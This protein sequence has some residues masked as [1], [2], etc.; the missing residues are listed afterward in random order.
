MAPEL[1]YDLLTWDMPEIN[2]VLDEVVLL[3]LNEDSEFAIDA[4]KMPIINTV[5]ALK[6]NDFNCLRSLLKVEIVDHNPL[7]YEVGEC[8]I[9]FWGSPA[10]LSSPS[11]TSRTT[12]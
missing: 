12:G 11:R 9:L 10:F 7:A 2:R 5:K 4:L 8:P 1:V 3:L 6:P